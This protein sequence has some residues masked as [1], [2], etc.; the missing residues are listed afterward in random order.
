MVEGE[1]GMTAVKC[2]WGG[3]RRSGIMESRW[4]VGLAHRPRL[5]LKSCFFAELLLLELASYA[6]A[7]T[8]H[9]HLLCPV[10]L[11]VLVLIPKSWVTC[12]AISIQSP[13]V[14]HEQGRTALA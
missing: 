12:L 3:G 13:A 1:A 9:S 5:D 7:Q 8:K 11:L 2:V 4:A 6:S 14:R 10:F